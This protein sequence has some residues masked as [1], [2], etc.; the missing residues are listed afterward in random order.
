MCTYM[1]ASV[2]YICGFSVIRAKNFQH[3]LSKPVPSQTEDNYCNL[4][5]ALSTRSNF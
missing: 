2:I 5:K 3:Q 4:G 1:H